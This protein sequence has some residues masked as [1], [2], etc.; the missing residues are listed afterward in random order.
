MDDSAWQG[1]YLAVIFICLGVIPLIFLQNSSNQDEIER[2]YTEDALK[3]TA[4]EI[5]R[6]KKDE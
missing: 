6:D 4:Y 3:F 2:Q 1:V 5:T